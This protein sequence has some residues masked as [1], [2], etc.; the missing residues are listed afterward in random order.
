MYTIRSVHAYV[1]MYHI[2]ICISNTCRKQTHSI[3]TYPQYA[4]NACIHGC[5]STCHTFLHVYMRAWRTITRCSIGFCRTTRG[6]GLPA[7]TGTRWTCQAT[8]RSH[9][10]EAKQ[11][12]TNNETD[13]H[14]H[15]QQQ[16][17][18]QQQQQQQSTIN[19]QQINTHTIKNKQSNK[20]NK[21]LPQGA[22]FRLRATTGPFSSGGKAPWPCLSHNTVDK[23]NRWNKTTWNIQ[24]MK[25][26]RACK[27]LCHYFMST[28]NHA[29]S[30][31]I[32]ML[33]CWYPR[34]WRYPARPLAI[35]LGPPRSL[36]LLSIYIYVYII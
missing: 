27:L 30:C 29:V 2:N 6:S 17:Q 7:S 16:R 18:Q 8:A 34:L 26:K 10:E 15:K 36:T 25:D 33:F 31:C 12:T 3:A 32:S 24:P 19:N 13:T 1:C 20:I 23:S 14:T 4:G 28:L 5:M 22:A 21:R 9:A 35:P 11:K